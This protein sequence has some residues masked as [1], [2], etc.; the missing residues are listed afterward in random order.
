MTSAEA[1]DRLLDWRT[2]SAYH[3]KAYV[4][5]YEETVRRCK[6]HREDEARES[7]AAISSAEYKRILAQFEPGP[8]LLTRLET[9]WAAAKRKTE[10]KP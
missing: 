6:W 4:F 7:Q 5:T 2:P 1:L 3:T 9:W 10:D 8:S